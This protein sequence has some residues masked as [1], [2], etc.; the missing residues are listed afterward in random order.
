MG[1]CWSWKG[2][3]GSRNG[4]TWVKEKWN[5]NEN[6]R[7]PID[8][9]HICGLL[10]CIRADDLFTKEPVTQT[11]TSPDHS[12]SWPPPTDVQHVPHHCFSGTVSVCATFAL[13]SAWLSTST[14]LR[15][16]SSITPAGLAS[17]NLAP[18]RSG[19]NAVVTAIPAHTVSEFHIP[20]NSRQVYRGNGN[21]N[22]REAMRRLTNCDDRGRDTHRRTIGRSSLAVHGSDKVGLSD[23]V[24]DLGRGRGDHVA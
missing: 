4:F 17:S 19:P 21:R 12:A 8:S 5:E 23:G 3:K 16:I 18:R 13:S 11:K 20:G 7:W 14:L 22:G 15:R 6:G 2:T 24:D 1:L 9:H 10:A